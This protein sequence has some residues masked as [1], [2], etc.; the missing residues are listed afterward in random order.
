[1]NKG[2]F[3]ELDAI[4][5]LTPHTKLATRPSSF[6]KLG[7]DIRNAYRLAYFG[8]P[9]P[10]F[11]D[12]PADIIQG[13]ARSFPEEG[14]DALERLRGAVSS[15]PSSPKPAGDPATIN[16]VAKLLFQAQA[17]LIVLGK[18]AAYSRAEVAIRAFVSQAGI[19]FLPTPMG[20]GVVA[21]SHPSNAASARSAALK[22]ADVVLVLGARLNWILHYGEAPKWSPAATLVQVDICPEEIGRNA[23]SIEYGIVGD[24][25]LVVQQLL[26]VMKSWRWSARPL[27][28]PLPA[29]MS[30]SSTYPDVIARQRAKNEATVEAKAC[31]P[32]ESGAPMTYHR[33]FHIIKKT[34]DSL[35]PPENG[36]IIYVSEGANTM[37]ISRTIFSVE[38]PRHRLDAG[39]FA[40]MGVGLGYIIGA[41]AARTLSSSPAARARAAV[42]AKAANAATAEAAAA[43]ETT[44]EDAPRSYRPKKIVA[45]EGDSAF[46]FSGMDV[47]TLARYRIPALI[48]VINNNGIYHA[49][50]ATRDD[51]ERLQVEDM[52]ETGALRSTGLLWETRYEKLAEMVGGK[53]HFVRTEQ[54]LRE[55]TAQGYEER[56]RVTVVNVMVEPGSGKKVKFAWQGGADSK[57]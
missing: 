28:P 12:L 27:N 26:G 1:M 20:K 52:K 40:T 54:E 43:A 56:D 6:E 15:S 44:A 16:A 32:T 14:K 8:R 39:T 41:Y 29:P 4:S 48:F 36:D 18:G 10:T 51:W 46:G 49:D 24:I 35:S 9:G 33:V 50:A 19:P 2:A 34:L 13:T 17:P 7:F 37:D 30:Q 3:Q 5:L 22:H 47:E 25:A 42:A 38:H 57:L 31:L 55:A 45:F 11:V 21:D 53:G 23:G